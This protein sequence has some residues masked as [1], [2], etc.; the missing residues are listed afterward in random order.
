MRTAFA[1]MFSLMFG[2]LI[3][4]TLAVGAVIVR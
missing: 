1:L 2:G 4:T 3:G